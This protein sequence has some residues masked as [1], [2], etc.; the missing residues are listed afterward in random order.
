MNTKE[1]LIRDY[2]ARQVTINE[3]RLMILKSPKG[4]CLVPGF[5]GGE[6]V[7]LERLSA[8]NEYEPLPDSLPVGDV[9]YNITP[10]LNR[11]DDAA[12]KEI[13]TIMANSRA[14]AAEHELNAPPFCFRPNGHYWQVVYEGRSL[15][16][17]T[18]TKGIQD[19]HKLLSRPH[20]PIEAATLYGPPPPPDSNSPYN[21]EEM[22]I[23]G[24][25]RQT[26]HDLRT[27]RELLHRKSQIETRLHELENMMNTPG[28][29][30]DAREEHE[31]TTEEMR[32]IDEELSMPAKATFEP[33]AIK[34]ARQA[35][36]KRINA[37]IDSLNDP[38]LRKH[39]HGKIEKGRTC[40][41]RGSP[42]WATS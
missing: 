8:F 20:E 2:L 27:R 5:Q 13:E 9:Y 35:V 21:P 12:R 31:K 36:C 42:Q 17:I 14:E 29:S 19:I 38:Q 33:P 24:A 3:A 26:T 16:N 37:A 23:E 41:Y 1:E 30:L 39:L 28:E 40:V 11:R 7:P 6:L 4:A 18:D 25:C 32:Q 34:R 10:I 15:G 22:Q